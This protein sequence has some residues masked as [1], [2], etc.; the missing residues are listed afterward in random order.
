MPR[1]SFEVVEIMSRSDFYRAGA[2]SWI[3][4]G[5]GDDRESGG[6]ERE[7]G[8]SLPMSGSIALIVRMDGDGRVAEHRFGPCRRDRI[9][10]LPSAKG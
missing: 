1:A 10:S 9:D 5:I 7:G 8:R 4:K 6:C 3:D 2:K